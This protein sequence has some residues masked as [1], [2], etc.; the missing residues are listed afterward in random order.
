[1]IALV[2]LLPLVTDAGG[3]PV[4]GYGYITVG[5][6]AGLGLV[7]HPAGGTVLV[8]QQNGELRIA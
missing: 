7:V 5:V 6:A 4:P 2:A 3:E 8:D 1:V